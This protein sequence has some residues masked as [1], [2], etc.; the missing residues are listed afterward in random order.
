MAYPA[1]AKVQSYV[2]QN[3]DSSKLSEPGVQSWLSHSAGKAYKS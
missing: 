1:P 2:N 3:A